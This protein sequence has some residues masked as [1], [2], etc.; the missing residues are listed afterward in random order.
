MLEGEQ[1]ENFVEFKAILLEEER[2]T[3]RILENLTEQLVVYATGAEI[4][5]A[6]RDSVSKIVEATRR[7]NGGLRSLFHRI[8]QSDL[9]TH[10]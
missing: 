5:F 8:I 1:F 6:D 10:R 9:F 4:Q 2:E 3:G 7:Q